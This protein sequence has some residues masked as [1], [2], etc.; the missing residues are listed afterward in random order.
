MGK[1]VGRQGRALDDGHYST[2]AV[3]A[4]GGIQLRTLTEAQLQ[5][6]HYIFYFHTSVPQ[7]FRVKRTYLLHGMV[8]STLYSAQQRGCFVC[9]RSST[10]VTTA[11]A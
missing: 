1:R 10:L 5:R 8:F 4:T 2:Q 9:F 3:S 11:S 6:A 7:T